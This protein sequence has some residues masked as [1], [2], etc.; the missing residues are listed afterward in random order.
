MALQSSVLAC[1]TGTTK[2]SGWTTPESLRAIRREVPPVEPSMLL[3]RP[4][5][6][7]SQ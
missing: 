3:K 4:K 2:T 7:S 5:P 1:S 6:H